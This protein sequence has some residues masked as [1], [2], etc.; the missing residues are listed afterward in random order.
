MEEALEGSDEGGFGFERE[1]EGWRVEREKGD[2]RR[3]GDGR[4]SFVLEYQEQELISALQLIRQLP[5]ALSRF[6]RSLNFES[7]APEGKVISSS[8]W[9][10]ALGKERK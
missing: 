6:Y 5:T 2:G 9:F 3:S 7:S 10:I 1:A 4:F 8:F